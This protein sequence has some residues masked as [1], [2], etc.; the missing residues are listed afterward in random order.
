MA[1][2]ARRARVVSIEPM[3]EFE[4]SNVYL[5]DECSPERW[6]GARQALK[7][8]AEA[9][10][11]LPDRCRE[12]VWLR[13]VEELSQ[14][15]V[16]RRYAEAGIVVNASADVP[17]DESDVCY[18]PAREVVAAVTSAGLAEVMYRLWP[19]ASLKGLD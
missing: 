16:N 14:K 15:E 17:L 19:L 12:V 5:V 6:M 10:E 13:R 1:D 8:L 9:L 4:P 18:K 3:G 7:R 11:R 2:R